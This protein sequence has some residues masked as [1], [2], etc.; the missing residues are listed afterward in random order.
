ALKPDVVFRFWGG[1]PQMAKTLERFGARVVTL[2]YPGDF[3]SVK[4][5]IRTVAA[6]LDRKS[7]G[8]AMIAA[9]DRRLTALKEKPPT[10]V[11]AL[12]VTPGGVT[13]GKGA[14]LD[15]ILKT[16]GVENLAANKKGWP[17]LPME[18]LVLNPPQLIVAGFF[19]ATTEYVNHW[20]AARHPAFADIFKETP[21]VKLDAD[22]ISC[23]AWYSVEAAEKIAA[24]AEAL[25]ENP[26]AEE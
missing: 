13:A 10:H 26:D 5:D 14:M 2:D 18:E 22:L 1:A 11:A 21:T 20:S 7:Q 16:A 12:Y 24:R 6:A 15:A 9:L 4:R 25:E 19:G 23:P 17:S 8:D 3:D